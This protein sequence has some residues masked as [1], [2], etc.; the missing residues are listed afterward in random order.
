M[1]EIILTN[2]EWTQWQASAD[3]RNGFQAGAY[4]VVEPEINVIRLLQPDGQTQI[5][6]VVRVTTWQVA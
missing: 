2:D 4:S 5:A 1:K 3:Y 6:Q